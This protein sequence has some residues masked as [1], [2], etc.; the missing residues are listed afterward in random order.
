MPATTQSEFKI[1]DLRSRPTDTE[2]LRNLLEAGTPFIPDPKRNGF[3]E[4][5]SGSLVYYIHVSPATGNVLL[6]AAWSNDAER[7]GEN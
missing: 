2:T 3:Y 7:S 1:E 4:V 6:L 5:E